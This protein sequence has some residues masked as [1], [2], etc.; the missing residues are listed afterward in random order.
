MVDDSPSEISLGGGITK[1]EETNIVSTQISERTEDEDTVPLF[2]MKF[3][4]GEGRRICVWKVYG[5]E[6]FC[7]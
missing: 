4:E 3:I 5:G 1:K 2:K 7:M 6:I